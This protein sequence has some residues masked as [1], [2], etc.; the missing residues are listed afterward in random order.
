MNIEWSLCSRGG[1][2]CRENYLRARIDV[3]GVA[4]VINRNSNLR[5]TQDGPVT[6]EDPIPQSS[7]TNVYKNV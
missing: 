5:A 2:R 7:S 3:V 1:L 4:R 6:I